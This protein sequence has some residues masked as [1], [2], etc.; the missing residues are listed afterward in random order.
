MEGMSHMSTRTQD[1]RRDIEQARNG[2]GETLEAIGDRVAPKKVVGR[3]KENVADKVEDVRDRI[4][5]VRIVKRRTGAVRGALGRIVG[6]DDG[7][8]GRPGGQVP[9]RRATSAARA[10]AT[11]GQARELSRRAGRTV[12]SVAQSARSAP[13]AVRERAEGNPLAA[14]LF[15]LAAGFFVGS[16][17]PPTDN[18]RRLLQQAKEEME[19]MRRELAETGRSIAGELQQSA[20]QS[21]EELKQVAAQAAERVKAEAQS[22]AQE[23]KTE[24]QEATS[25]VK[26]ETASATRAVKRTTQRAK[27]T[28]KAEAQS[29]ARAVKGRA[30]GAAT[31]ARSPKPAAARAGTRTPTAAKTAA[32]RSPGAVKPRTA[33]RKA[34]A[35]GR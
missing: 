25:S 28:V 22:G 20:Q 11:D 31:S 24:A 19:P 16:L 10:D 35:S 29:S 21:V 32:D 4:S 15:V 27:G 12:D 30:Q 26:A 34:S 23:V 6:S 14:G 7:D 3:A 33:G 18:E 17:L 8:D 5:P 2:L 9:T 13:Q 1:L